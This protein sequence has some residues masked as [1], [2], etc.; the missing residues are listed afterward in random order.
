MDISPVPICWDRMYLKHYPLIQKNFAVCPKNFPVS[1]DNAALNAAPAFW[2]PEYIRLIIP[3]HSHGSPN[4]VT[5]TG[6][7]PPRCALVIAQSWIAPSLTA[8]AG[9]HSRKML[10]L[11]SRRC[12][13][14]LSLAAKP[15]GT[16][17]CSALNLVLLRE[18]A[19]AASG[20]CFQQLEVL[21]AL[22]SR[23]TMF[24]IAGM[25]SH[26]M[27]FCHPCP[28]PTDRGENKIRCMRVLFICLRLNWA[29]KHDRTQRLIY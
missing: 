25:S 9:S 8:S 11:R 1:E 17:L 14:S 24:S 28:S 2:Q 10:S 18:A 13:I 15:V 22:P 16:I 12:F 6:E 19:F 3:V 26:E 7:A 29:Y 21:F 5:Y 20:N 4:R 23:A 27:G